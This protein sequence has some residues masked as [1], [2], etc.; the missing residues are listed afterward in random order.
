MT[1]TPPPVHDLVW[2]DDAV[3]RFWA[4]QAHS[5][6]PYFAENFGT[7]IAR[8]FARHVPP[9][10]H[11]IDLGCGSGGL[12]G[13]LLA[14][15]FIVS[16]ADDSIDNVERVTRQFGHEPRFLGARLTHAAGEPLPPADAVFSVE[17]VE[18][19]IDQRLG[20]YFDTI[21]ACLKPGGVL[22]VT[23]P[24]DEDLEG[25]KVF[26]PESGAVFHPMQ[27]MRSFDSAELR[28]FLAGFGFEARLVFATDFGLSLRTPKLWIADKAKRLLGM[29]TRPP[30]LVAIA[31]ARPAAAS[32]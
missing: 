5:P 31:R 29:G 32:R 17:T 19:I 13:A 28:S 26:C 3:R 4:Y 18:H 7:E 27:H 25:A 22:I 23:T 11:C 14:R 8:R 16:A 21:R 2:D 24:N 30:H 20:G 9:G 6:R 1:S 10:G 15:G 12:V